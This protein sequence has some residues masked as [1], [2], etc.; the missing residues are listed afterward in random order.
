MSVL[1]DLARVRERPQVYLRIISRTISTGGL[2]NAFK[3]RLPFRLPDAEYPY[4][5]VGIHKRLQSAVPV[6]RIT[7]RTCSGPTRFHGGLDFRE[8]R[9]TALRVFPA[10]PA[11][12]WGRGTHH[13]P[14]IRRVR[15][16]T[17]RCGEGLDAHDKLP[18]LL[19]EKLASNCSLV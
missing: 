16:S 2:L 1:G 8:N 18:T 19:R 14:A 17:A 3:S 15:N 5:G 4:R 7:D 13:A 11:G 12:H 6:L 10:N 9:L